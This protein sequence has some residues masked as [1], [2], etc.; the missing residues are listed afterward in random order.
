MHLYRHLTPE[1]RV[2]ARH[3]P[4]GYTEKIESE[5]G[6]IYHTPDKLHA[7]AY[8]GKAA[9]HD[10][11][12]SFRKPEDLDAKVKTFF[13]GLAKH[14]EIIRGCRN[15]RKMEHVGTVLALWQKAQANSGEGGYYLSTAET[16]LLVRERLKQ[17][18]PGIRF[19]VC[20]KSYAGGS[21]IHVGWTDGPTQREVEKIT[22]PY[23]GAGFD[24][25]IDL[26]Y[27][28][29]RWLYA[30]G[31]VSLAHNPGTDGSRGDRKSTRLNSS[32]RL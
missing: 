28:V 30:D 16:A 24:G 20:S 19:S 22:D 10:W 14:R 17:E 5:N 26:K 4:Q 29:A 9:R 31:T 15:K 32:H 7:I 12:Y 3:I 1:Q 21:S 23:E 6:V 8:H 18:F 27:Y 2:A 13:E 25:M 11:H